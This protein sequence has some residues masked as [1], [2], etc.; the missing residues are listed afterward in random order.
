MRFGLDVNWSIKEHSLILYQIKFL[1]SRA[2]VEA[3]VTNA[4]TSSYLKLVQMIYYNLN[5][6]NRYEYF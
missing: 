2:K 5:K 6:K 4:F 3:V 1:R